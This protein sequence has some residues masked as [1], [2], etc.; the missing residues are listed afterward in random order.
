MALGFGLMAQ[1]VRFT[2][3]GYR[4]VWVVEPVGLNLQN[5]VQVYGCSERDAEGLVGKVPTNAH[6]KTGTELLAF[7]DY[8]PCFGRIIGWPMACESQSRR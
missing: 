1:G 5:L 4:A 6:C 2:V 3:L 8:P 7:D